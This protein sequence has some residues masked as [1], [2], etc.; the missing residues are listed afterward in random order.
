MKYLV[1]SINPDLDS[2]ISKRF[3]HSDFFLV[4]DS[5]NFEFE[6]ISGVGH[7]EASY[8]IA[9]FSGRDVKG[10]IVVNIGPGAFK[11]VRNA[12]WLVYSCPGLTVREAVEKVRLGSVPALTAPTMKHSV[13]SGKKGTG[14]S[15]KA[16][17]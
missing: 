4:V 1:A 3:G 11:D 7:D 10:V 13:H 5:E 17:S 6:V 8:S 14:H 9:R 15:D 12:G 16:G 2:K